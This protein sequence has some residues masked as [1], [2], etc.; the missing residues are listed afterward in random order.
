MATKKQNAGPNKAVAKANEAALVQFPKAKVTRAFEAMAGSAAE[1]DNAAEAKAN[2]ALELVQLAHD[3]RNANAD[4]TTETV[5]QGWRD[6][7]KL[8]TMELAVAGNKFAELTPAKDD[9]PATAK[10]TGYGNNVASIAKG[11]LEFDIEPG[12]SYRDTR[13]AVEAARAE[14]R[15][16]AD[17]DAAALADAKEAAIDALES[18][19]KAVFETGDAGLIAGL[20]QMARDGL[21]EFEAAQAE[22]DAVEAEAQAA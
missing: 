3:F 10:L 15:R 2:A 1:A 18:L 9:K 21:A 6:N 5:I 14:H 22:Q 11:S 8:V 12:E 4:A 20:E 17:P 19:R 16:Q 13:K 7:L